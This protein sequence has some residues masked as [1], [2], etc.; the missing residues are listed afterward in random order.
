MLTTKEP[1]LMWAWVCPATGMVLDEAWG[2]TE[3]YAKSK[4]ERLWGKRRTGEGDML[5][6]R[7]TVEPLTA[8]ETAKH[9]AEYEE[10]KARKQQAA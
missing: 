1:R 3:P 10:W 4:S 6:C 8:D 2:A 7:V 9:R 5:L